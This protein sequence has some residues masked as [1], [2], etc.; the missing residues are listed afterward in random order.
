MRMIDADALMLKICGEGCGC[1]PDQC[2][3]PYCGKEANEIRCRTGEY[4][5]NAPTIDAI[6]VGW[7][8]DRANDITRAPLYR[9]YAQM[10]MDEWQKEQEA[11]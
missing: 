1:M 10:L 11:R 4:V 5:E 8:D 6:P 3:Y 2:G 9:R 7:L